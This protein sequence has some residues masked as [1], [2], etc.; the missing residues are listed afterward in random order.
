MKIN[1]GW[2]IV[3]I[4]MGVA[5][6]VA[7]AS[8]GGSTGVGSGGGSVI[9]RADG[10]NVSFAQMY[11]IWEYDKLD[12]QE[13]NEIKAHDLVQ[14]RIARLAEL[15][16]LFA[17]EVSQRVGFIEKEIERNLKSGR[18]VSLMQVLAPQGVELPARCPNNSA[19]LAAFAQIA[20]YI[21][22]KDGNEDII[23]LDT[24]IYA[25]FSETSRATLILHEAFFKIFRET[26]G[27]AN[28]DHAKYLAANL[29]AEVSDEVL[30][31][32]LKDLLIRTR[33][34]VVSILYNDYYEKIF[35]SA[36]LGNVEEVGRLLTRPVIIYKQ[37][38]D[39]DT[40]IRLQVTEERG[41]FVP[42]AEYAEIGFQDYF[43]DRLEE[44]MLAMDATSV[45]DIA[46]LRIQVPGLYR[47]QELDACT[48][49]KVF[50]RLMDK[51]SNEKRSSFRVLKT[52]RNFWR[53]DTYSFDHLTEDG[54]LIVAQVNT[55]V[56]NLPGK[57]SFAC[58]FEWKKFENPVSFA[59]YA[60]DIELARMML[61]NMSQKEIA[62]LSDASFE[63]NASNLAASNE[64]R[65]LLE[66]YGIKGQKHPWE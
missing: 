16:P 65:A 52:K 44:A 5:P 13:S 31:P 33:F 17:D 41:G 30:I 7:L 42:T 14:A 6:T 51:I 64:M 20:N 9:C 36:K 59:A 63:E 18:K 43:G 15:N 50:R 49:G 4:L 62:N 34:S 2:S 10:V 48:G 39:L 56:L 53:K 54:K 25:A 19:T 3:L 46:H 61:Q 24:E 58:A 38:V 8:N 55:L 23:H 22:A 21:D 26:L 12:I 35:A 27:E 40:T 29:M 60:N 47:P 45:R 57:F 11:E 28:A 37:K 32:I 1:K 66:P